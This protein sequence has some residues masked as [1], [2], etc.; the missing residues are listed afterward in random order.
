MK[1]II[2]KSIDKDPAFKST[3]IDQ[4][5]TLWLY[6]KYIK[7]D[8]FLG[9]NGFMSMITNSQFNYAISAINFLP[10]I[11]GSPSDYSTLVYRYKI[12]F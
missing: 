5:H 12:R 1:Q 2:V 8:V 9:W 3:L 6:Y 11:N 7:D 4:L 10:F